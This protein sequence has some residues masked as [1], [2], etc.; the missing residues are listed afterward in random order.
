MGMRCV[1]TPAVKG[2][3]HPERANF[4]DV[5]HLGRRFASARVREVPLLR[6]AELDQPDR[7]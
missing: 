1:P 4:D 5:R 3:I 7:G 2:S 6:A